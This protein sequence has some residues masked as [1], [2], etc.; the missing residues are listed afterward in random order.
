SNQRT[1]EP[2]ELVP[3]ERARAPTI[4]RTRLPT[5]ELI[6][7]LDG[8]GAASSALEL[9]ENAPASERTG[10]S[11]LDFDVPPAR[12][13]H[14]PPSTDSAQ[15]SMKDRYALGDYTGALV[16]AE[17]ILARQPE[18]LE[19]LHYAER[20]REVLTQMYSARLGSLAQTV[21]IAIPNDEIRWLSLDHRAGF[22][23]SLVDGT[24]TIEEILDISGMSRLDALRVIFTLV[25]PRVI[26]LH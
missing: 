19:A 6:L 11:E 4:P 3:T 8:P 14:E 9:A 22:L 21:V 5:A 26:T 18:H 25:D 23:L 15:A 17:D 10:D 7:D 24:L 20:C 2:A 13:T 12:R 1:I 16:A